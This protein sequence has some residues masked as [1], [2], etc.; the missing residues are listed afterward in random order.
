LAAFLEGTVARLR[1]SKLTE[2]QNLLPFV[3]CNLLIFYTKD[4][5]F[6]V[7]A[8]LLAHEDKLRL[9]TCF[10]NALDWKTL[11]LTIECNSPLLQDDAVTEL[12]ILVS[13]TL[14]TC[15]PSSRLLFSYS[16]I[17]GKALFD[18]E[19][20]SDLEHLIARCSDYLECFPEWN[21]NCGHAFFAQ[22]KY[23]EAVSYYQAAL[24]KSR[25]SNKTILSVPPVVLA[26][27]CV[28]LIETDQNEIAEGLINEILSIESRS[29]FGHFHSTIVNLLVGY[30]Y[31]TKENAGFGMLRVLEA[32]ED[33]I[34][35]TP[36]TWVIFKKTCMGVLNKAGCGLC[37]I[38]PD[39]VA[40]KI[41][42]FLDRVCNILQPIP[43]GETGKT[44]QQE[45][46]IIDDL[47][48]KV[49]FH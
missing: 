14:K 20:F 21:I 41:L 35:I 15:E 27:L 7:A 19:R 37:S 9:E 44:V 18:S 16:C 1:D 34:N 39:E 29:D 13:D 30:L 46:K 10:P 22:G 32:V 42:K 6:E 12:Q 33:D 24:E 45:A 26:N 25:R 49:F 48:R 38:I 36:E 3:I 4:Q 40:S 5:R 2:Q 31:C 17:L 8:E 28:A 47:M 11:R 23:T 43:S